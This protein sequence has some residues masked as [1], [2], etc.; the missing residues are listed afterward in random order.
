MAALSERTGVLVQAEHRNVPDASEQ[1]MVQRLHLAETATITLT[2]HQEIRRSEESRYDHRLHAVLLIVQGITCPEVAK[3]L[4][5]APRTV[6]YWL[7]RYEKN[8]IAGLGEQPK[9]GRPSRLSEKQL[10]E[11]KAA[12]QQV[13]ADLPGPSLTGKALAAWIA[14]HYGVSLGVR[15][16]QRL[17]R[18]LASRPIKSRSF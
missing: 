1:Q 4:G 18:Q 13:Q 14:E 2:L 11:V 17:L 7:D 10:E 16:C 3:L 15:Q 9:S 6:E 5:E 12:L 8:G